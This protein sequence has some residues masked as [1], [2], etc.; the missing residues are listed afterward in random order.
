MQ[1]VDVEAFRAEL[2]KKCGRSIACIRA[3]EYYMQLVK[4]PCYPPSVK[5][6]HKVRRHLMELLRT[7]GNP[8]CN[9]KQL[10]I[11]KLRGT[12]FE[13]LAE[14]IAEAAYVIRRRMNISSRVAAAVATY[15]VVRRRRRYVSITQLTKIYNISGVSI[16]KN[17]T[18]A[19]KI[20]NQKT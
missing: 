16:S 13:D 2:T 9:V 15:I 4:D 1:T 14:E 5:L 18:E 19:A 20:L 17:A 12:E 6:T 7:Y 3:V 11:E 8:R 10:V